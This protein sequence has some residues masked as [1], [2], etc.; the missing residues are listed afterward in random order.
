MAHGML[1]FYP[2]MDTYSDES[3]LGTPSR[4]YLLV[5]RLRPSLPRY[6][7]RDSLVDHSAMP[8]DRMSPAASGILAGIFAGAAGF[9]VVHGLALPLIARTVANVAHARGWDPAVVLG[10]AYAIAAVAGSL[11]GAL[12]AV[13]TRYLRKWGPLLVWALVF[14]VSLAMLILAVPSV[15]SRVASA[16]LLRVLFAASAAFAVVVSFSLPIRRRH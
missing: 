3:E 4:P 1:G 9:G 8:S 10:G 7:D 14:F 12:F 15:N 16:G 11:V 5:H 6:S 13:V 2:A